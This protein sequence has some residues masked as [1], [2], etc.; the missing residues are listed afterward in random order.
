MS[1][2][3]EKCWH[4]VKDHGEDG[5]DWEVSDWGQLDCGCTHVRAP[6]HQR[7]P[8]DACDCETCQ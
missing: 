7:D 5:C 6:L 3:C 8:G 2:F 1:D 4:P